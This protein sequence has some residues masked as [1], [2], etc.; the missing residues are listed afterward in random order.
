MS[1]ANVLPS[2][3]NL[4]CHLQQHPTDKTLTAYMLADLHG[5]F[6]PLMKPDCEHFNPLPAAAC[7]M[8]PVLV[9]PELIPLC[10]SA[11]AYFI[12]YAA[13]QSVSTDDWV[14]LYVMVFI[15]V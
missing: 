9:A 10:L 11:K 2:I 14:K 4:E 3:L 5:R 7:L 12:N 6:E 13:E 8:D 15:Q 1:L